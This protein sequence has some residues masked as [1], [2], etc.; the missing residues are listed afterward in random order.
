M[1]NKKFAVS[2]IMITVG[3]LFCMAFLMIWIDPDF[4]YH[5]SLDYISY[6]MYDERYQNDGISK[7][8]DYD[9]II[10]GTSMTQ[11]FKTS[12]FDNLFKV[13]SIKIS[14]AGASLKEVND[15]LE[16]ATE[17]N[18]NINIIIRSLDWY[19]IKADKDTQS[20]ST[21]PEYL[22]D[23]NLLNDINYILNK[24]IMVRRLLQKDIVYT[25]LGKE[26]TT[27]DEY[28]NWNANY[29]F[30]K[31]YVLE[32]YNRL[33]KVEESSAELSEEEKI[34]IKENIEQNV[35]ALAIDNPEIQFYCFYA[36]YSIIY[37]DDLNQQGVLEKNIAIIEYATS[38]LVEQ[39]NIKLFSFV[40]C[41]DVILEL[42]NYKDFQHYSEDINSM[43]LELMALEQNLLTE[44]NYEDYFA[45]IYAFY[46]TYD[47]ET[48]FE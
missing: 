5:K 21:Y 41:Y 39:D 33:D 40:D 44:D 38:L 11:N 36:P 7:N 8:F 30:G 43:M 27:F 12:E 16:R 23:D 22:Y 10:T 31:E 17:Y 29:E 6:V 15:S 20:Y 3:T 13:N 9:A 48:L 35:L 28:S 47:Y 46:S 18:D 1:P 26:S 25:L 45:E 19:A 4:H 42:D 2:I 37:Y 32:S 34:A 24:D 14:Y